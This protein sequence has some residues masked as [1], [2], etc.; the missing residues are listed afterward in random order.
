MPNL[1]VVGGSAGSIRVLQQL[2]GALP[3]DLDA[4]LC[5]VVHVP[6]LAP[7]ALPSVL[8]RVSP[9]AA[10]HAVDGELLFGRSLVGLVGY[11]DF[12]RD[13][14]ALFVPVFVK[15]AVALLGD[16]FQIF[17]DRIDSA[18]AAEETQA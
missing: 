18:G 9:L 14:R 5:V 10:H 4:A 1:V 15:E 8:N 17:V 12:A 7:S 13:H 16:R 11:G 3:P 6:P 2:V